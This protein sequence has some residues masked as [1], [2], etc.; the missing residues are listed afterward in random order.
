[1]SKNWNI[2]RFINIKYKCLKKA[3]NVQNYH[4]YKNNNY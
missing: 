3:H 1:M 4:Y 2:K